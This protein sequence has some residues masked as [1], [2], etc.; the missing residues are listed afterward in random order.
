MPFGKAEWRIVKTESEVTRDREG[1]LPTVA[2]VQHV[3]GGWSI[4]RNKLDAILNTVKERIRGSEYDGSELMP[5]NIFHNVTKLDFF[6]VTANLTLLPSAI[7]KLKTLIVSP[8]TTGISLEKPDAVRRFLRKIFNA[9]DPARLEDKAIYNSLIELLGEGNYNLGR[10]RYMN[11]C[12]KNK[13]ENYTYSLMKGTT[14]ECLEPWV[15]KL[16]KISRKY[17]GASIREQNKMMTEI[18]FA[19][20]EKIPYATFLKFIGK[21]NYVFYIDVAGFRTGDE[22]AIDGSYMSN[23]IG[24]PEKKRPYSQGLIS[25]IADKSKIISTELNRTQADFQ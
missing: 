5:E 17:N 9:K 19:L 8:D 4:K 13:D 14:Y 20:E 25:V 21:E 22:N 11:E 16:I 6:R 15:E 24:E 10:D 23:I 7:D 12:M 3:W 1:G 2:T 18:I